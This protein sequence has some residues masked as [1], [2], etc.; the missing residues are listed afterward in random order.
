MPPKMATTTSSVLRTLDTNQGDKALL[1]EVRNQKR[2]AF[3]LEPQ[4][5]ELDQEI[6]NHEAI[7][8]QWRSVGRRC[9]VFLN[10]RKRLTKQLKK[11]TTLKHKTRTTIGTRIMRA[12]T[13]TIFV[14]N[15]STSKTS[16]MIKLPY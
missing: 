10:S 12:S 9:F 6:D 15:Q 2:K 3:N 14:M 11:C 7:H 13:M 4:D 1:K 16:S 8:Q 5:Q